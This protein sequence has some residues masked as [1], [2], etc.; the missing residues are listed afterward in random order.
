M[1]IVRII[2]VLLIV[3]LFAFA[4]AIDKWAVDQVAHI[5]TS[6]GGSSVFTAE[7]DPELVADA[8]PFALKLY[9]SLLETTPENVNLLLTTGQGFTM[10]AFAFVQTPADYLPDAEFETK[11]EMLGRAK[12]LFLRGRNYILKG[13]EIRRPGFMTYL[14]EN[15]IDAAM[16]LVTEADIDFLYWGALAWMGAF[17]TDSFDLTLLIDLPKPIAM[18]SKVL[19]FDDTYADGGA[20]D[21]FIS[22]YGSLPVTA[23]GSEEKARFH[24]KKSVEI[25]QGRSAAPYLNLATTVSVAKQDLAEFRDLLEYVLALD[26]DL[27]PENRLANILS[28]EKAQWLLEHIDLFF[29]DVGDSELGE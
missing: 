25:S 5:L 17:T 26:V 12:R 16:A 21:I 27:Y 6:E 10:Y 1:K 7:D 13:L 23:G 19:E 20:H 29:I 14:Q 28:Q 18:L 4:C 24:F 3:L 8:L 15:D 2:L 11:M 9:E 22:Y